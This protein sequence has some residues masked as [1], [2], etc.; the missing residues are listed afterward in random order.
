M[1]KVEKP[2][3]AVVLSAHK[4]SWSVEDRIRE[5]VKKVLAEF[6]YLFM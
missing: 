3:I 4:N 2:T 6:E 5:M 1:Q